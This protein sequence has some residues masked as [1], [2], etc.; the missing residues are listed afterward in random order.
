[1]RRQ[2]AIPFPARGAIPTYDVAHLRRPIRRTAVA[3]I[4]LAL[5]LAGLVAAAALAA[6]QPQARAASFIEQGSTSLLV[7]DL[8]R[9]VDQLAYRTIRSTL[10]QVVAT[11]SPVGIV[12]FS[13][14]PYELVPPG[15][16]GSSLAPMLRVF[17]PRAGSSRSLDPLSG[18]PPSPWGDSFRAGTR[19][20]SALELARTILRR[21]HVPH[22]NVVLVSDLETA[23]SDAS[24]L[25]DELVRYRVDH[26]PLRLVALYP[27]PEARSLFERLVG[28]SAFVS[29]RQV[30]AAGS[31][32]AARESA[33]GAAPWLL[34]AAALVLA[35]LA[36]NELLLRGVEVPRR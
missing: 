9:S 33:R 4:V 16:P 6:R 18:Y 2:L 23:A 22:A 31:E 20:S 29:P 15:S 5:A 19:I 25:T 28:R 35:L 24:A 36:L 3:R 13:D 12:A 10:R 32:V 21:D 11:N 34:G 1:V 17:T 27:T 14:V 7:L 26:V 8:S 30:F